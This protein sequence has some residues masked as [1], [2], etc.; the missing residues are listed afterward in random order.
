MTFKSCFVKSGK[1]PYP[2]SKLKIIK[3]KSSHGKS[4]L[5]H[6]DETCVLKG[7][8]FPGG[9]RLCGIKEKLSPTDLF[10][11]ENRNILKFHHGLLAAIIPQNPNHG[12]NKCELI[13]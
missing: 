9:Y 3:D 10:F 2:F 7:C 8:L 13:F 12:L 4:W 6:I 5:F 11:I 1:V